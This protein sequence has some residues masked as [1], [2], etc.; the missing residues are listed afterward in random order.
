MHFNL[1]DW[2]LYVKCN[3]MHLVVLLKKQILRYFDS[4]CTPR[5]DICSRLFSSWYYFT[6]SCF[7]WDLLYN[8]IC[9]VSVKLNYK[10]HVLLWIGFRCLLRSGNRLLQV[11]LRI[12]YMVTLL[13]SNIVT[14]IHHRAPRTGLYSKQIEV[15]SATQAE[16]ITMT[17]VVGQ[18][19]V[20]PTRVL[21]G[22]ERSYLDQYALEP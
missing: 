21:N 6:S 2:S 20:I 1:V 4:Y 19:W 18:A 5:Q 9:S 14:G 8:T 3:A 13:V 7:Q 16:P 15:S 12:F 22:S 17:T 10:L 11:F